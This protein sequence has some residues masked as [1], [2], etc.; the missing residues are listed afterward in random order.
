M[1]TRKHFEA[2]ARIIRENTPPEPGDQ[3][4]N[5]KISQS[6]LIASDLADYFSTENPNFD[7]QKFAEAIRP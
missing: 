7:R 4:E 5:G 3:F 6:Y 2:V 1:M